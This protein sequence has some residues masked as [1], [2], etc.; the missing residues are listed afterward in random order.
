[1]GLYDTIRSSFD[2]GEEFTDKDLQTK[3]IQDCIGGTLDFYWIDNVGRL[4]LVD[5]SET[6]DPIKTN[7][8]F[9]LFKWIPNGNHGKVTPVY[10]TK[11]IEV[12]DNPYKRCKIHFKCGIVQDFEIINLEEDEFF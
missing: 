10:I 6:A 9:P 5:I 7:S 8:D 2:L 3:D 12:Y 11:Y 4:F 1:M